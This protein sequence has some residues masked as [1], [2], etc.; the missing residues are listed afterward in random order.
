MYNASVDCQEHFV[1]KFNPLANN[2]VHILT[3][4]S[5]VVEADRPEKLFVG[6]LSFQTN[7]KTLEAA[8]AKFGPIIDGNS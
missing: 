5:T 2:D 3:P 4:Y 6:R 1:I 7:E 8:F